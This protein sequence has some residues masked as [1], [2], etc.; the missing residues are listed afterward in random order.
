MGILRWQDG[1]GAIQTLPGARMDGT[2]AWGKKGVVVS[3]MGNLPVTL[4][5]GEAFDNNTAVIVPDHLDSLS[6][7]W[8]FCSSSVFNDTVRM[9]DQKMSVTSATLVKVPFD[10]DHWQ[11]VADEQYPD[12]LPQPYSDDPTQ[13]LFHGHPQPSTSPLHVAVARLLGYRW[14]AESDK[15]MELSDEARQWIARSQALNA[16]ADD[17]GIVCIPSV[18]GE[19]P[20]ATR[21]QALLAQAYGDE[22]SPALLEKLLNDADH[23]GKDL[24]SWLR[25]AF[26]DQHCQL[27]Q[28][29]PFVW[30]IWDGRRR[31]GFAALV[32][33][34][35]LDRS[36]LE[37]LTYTYLGDWI[38]RQEDGVKQD[39]DGAEA[40]LL[41]A[42]ELQQKLQLILKG[43]D[44]YDIFVRWK[45]LDEQPIGWEP[46]LNDG[47]RLNIRPFVEANILRKKPKIHWKKDRGKDPESAPWF[48][49]FKGDRINDHHLSLSEKQL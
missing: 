14:P 13:W 32:N 7:V 39:V 33:Y 38:R 49:V 20:A 11:K 43:E 30:H 31:D 47:V 17:D 9:I 19:E 45:P 41:A 44:P 4:Y 26:F 29:R 15:E 8:C 1:K 6:A 12:G 21:L 37:T 3:Q 23:A 18:R 46:D 16:L 27:F 10:L 2:E 35:T 40:R 22:W 5:S 34:H 42:Q 25:D 28:H 36:K 48:S 24:D